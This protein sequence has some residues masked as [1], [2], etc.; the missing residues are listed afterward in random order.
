ME[1]MMPDT[2]VLMRVLK[3]L[4]STKSTYCTQRAIWHHLQR[5]KPPHNFKS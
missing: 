4:H 2:M 3:P 5:R 1:F